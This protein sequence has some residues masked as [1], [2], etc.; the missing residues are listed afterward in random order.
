MIRRHTG[1]RAAV[2]A[3]T[4]IGKDFRGEHL[5]W[6]LDWTAAKT[7]PGF[8]EALLESRPSLAPRGCFHG[9]HRVEAGAVVSEEFTFEPDTP[10]RAS[11]RCP[12]WMMQM[13][14]RCDGAKTV[15]DHFTMLQAEGTV[16]EGGS[17]AEFAGIIA[18]LVSAGALR[19]SLPGFV[20]SWPEATLQA[21]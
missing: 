18:G 21:A 17:A 5:E 12:A 11:C 4:Q 14:L 10:L 19:V 9:T 3:R 6:F 1:T 2:T 7:Q 8:V 20:P 15:R 16:P 13:L